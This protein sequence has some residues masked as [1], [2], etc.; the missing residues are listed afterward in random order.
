MKYFLKYCLSICCLLA[1]LTPAHAQVQATVQLDSNVAE[2]GNPFVI[3]LLS[4]AVAGKPVQIDFSAW[5]TVLPRQNILDQ[6]AANNLGNQYQIDLR[7][8][9]FDAD[10]LTLPPLTIRLAGG[11]IAVTNSIEL[12]VIA[13][14]APPDL[15]DMAD[16]KDI[17]REPIWWTDY[18]PWALG[19]AGLA[20]LFFI[21]NWLWNRSQRRGSQSRALE[22]PPYELARRKLEIL[23]KKRLWEN[24]Q[25]KQYYGDLTFIL[26]EYLQ[27][28]YDIP[29]LESTTEETLAYLQER[30][31]PQHLQ[32]PLTETLLQADL[33]KFAKS[34]PPESFH[35]QALHQVQALIE[36]TRQ[37]PA[38]TPIPA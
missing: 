12:V 14:P 21:A 26:R 19:I 28:R 13:T 4:P 31:F 2:T 8:I 6:S 38:S 23:A 1:L 10:T 20:A 22:M 17:R 7:C 15:N 25:I 11:Q 9:T 24:G 37:E 32:Q 30:D 34:T 3:H 29:A 18:L 27:K 36:S 35:E 5:D 16:L 33:V